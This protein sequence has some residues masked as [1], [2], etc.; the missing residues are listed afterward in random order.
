MAV[1]YE[2]D[3]DVEKHH[4]SYTVVNARLGIG[5]SD[6]RWMV[7]LWST[8]LTDTEYVQVGFDAPL[9]GLFPD[10]GNPLNTFNAFP[11]APRMYGVTLRVRY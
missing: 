3:L 7:E 10:P 6:N 9:Q 8:N 2:W 1:N 11:A 4:S 5:R